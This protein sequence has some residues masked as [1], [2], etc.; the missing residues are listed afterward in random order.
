M[1]QTDLQADNASRCAQSSRTFR[2]WRPFADH[3]ARYLNAKVWK[4]DCFAP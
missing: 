4:G 2:R 1:V 3:R